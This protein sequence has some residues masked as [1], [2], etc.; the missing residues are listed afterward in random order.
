MT[1]LLRSPVNLPV[2]MYQLVW[3]CFLDGIKHSFIQSFIFQLNY[4]FIYSRK[5]PF[6]PR[7]LHLYFW[8][9]RLC[10]RKHGVNLWQCSNFIRICSN[11][12]ILTRHFISGLFFNKNKNTL[13]TKFR[14]II[15][16]KYLLTNE[17]CSI[18]SCLWQRP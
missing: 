14:Y 11:G 8:S 15:I 16:C 4:T 12:V 6:H 7:M 13:N 2:N 18:V 9:V 10:V 5:V 1:H 3:R 17:I